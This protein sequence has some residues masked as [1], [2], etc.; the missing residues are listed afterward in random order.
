MLHQI[1]RRN[2]GKPA[3]RQ[4]GKKDTTP[5]NTFLTPE[6]VLE[7]RRA[8]D[9]GEVG[10]EVAIKWKITPVNFSLIGRRKTW[11]WLAEEKKTSA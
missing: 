2:T 8:Y 3:T 9:R 6:Q 1:R 4:G 7:I 11:K 10:K 5:A